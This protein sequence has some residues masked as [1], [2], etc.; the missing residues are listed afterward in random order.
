MPKAQ[1]TIILGSM[2]LEIFPTDIFSAKTKYTRG[3]IT[4]IELIVTTPIALGLES[5]KGIK[6][7]L[8]LF[9]IWRKILISF[10]AYNA[11]LSG[12]KLWVILCSE[13][14]RNPLF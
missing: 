10:L 9:F 6:S 12:L 13:A 1:K 11:T 4:K 7:D 14:E 5:E 2:L 8:Y 3:D